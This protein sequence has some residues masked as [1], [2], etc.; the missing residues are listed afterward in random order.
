MLEK[1]ISGGQTGV[2]RAALDAALEKGLACGGWCPSGRRAEDGSIA[3]LYPVVE[4]E[5]ESYAERTLRNVQEADGTLILNRGPLVTGTAQT[6]KFAAREKKPYLIVNLDKR[7]RAKRI[8][9]WLD[10][11]GI[12]VLNVAGPRESRSPGVYDRARRLLRVVLELQEDGGRRSKVE[13]DE[14]S[15]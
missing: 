3:P 6:V 1:I 10:K 2:D 14:S 11:K 8:C 9:D 7:V 13:K 15:A 12:R 5:R 4:T